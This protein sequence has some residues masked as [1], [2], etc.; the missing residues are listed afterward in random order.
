MSDGAL[1]FVII[2]GIIWVFAIY[3]VLN[4]LFW[5]WVHSAMYIDKQVKRQRQEFEEKRRQQ[6]KER[7]V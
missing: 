4:P 7:N 2:L 3:T 6:K 1:I 5:Q